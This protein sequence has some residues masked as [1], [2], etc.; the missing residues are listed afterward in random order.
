M[1]GSGLSLPGSHGA[2]DVPGARSG[3]G[4]GHQRNP[5]ATTASP[6]SFPTATG[7]SGNSPGRDGTSSLSREQL[8]NPEMKGV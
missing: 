4:A 7:F 1:H 5:S 3:A 8:G 2:M 6:S